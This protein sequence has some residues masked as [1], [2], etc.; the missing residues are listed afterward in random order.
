MEYYQHPHEKVML[1]MDGIRQLQAARPYLP[2]LQWGQA[3]HGLRALDSL[4]NH[5]KLYDGWRSNM[6]YLSTRNQ[7]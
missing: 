2:L 5:Y 7:N 3:M 1:S 6:A 4:H